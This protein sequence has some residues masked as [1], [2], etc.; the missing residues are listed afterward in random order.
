MIRRNKLLFLVISIMLTI[1]YF[2]NLRTKLLFDN[3]TF[4]FTNFN[5]DIGSRKLIV[6]NIVHFI[7]FDMKTLNF[8]TF[9][10]LLSAWY[11]HKPSKIY[12]HTNLKQ[13]LADSFYIDVLKNVT[14]EALEIHEL[15]KPTHVF[16]QRLSSTHHSSDIARIQILMKYGGIYLDEDV[17]VVKNLNRF[18]HFECS[19]GWP[20]TQNIGSQVILAHKDA[21]FLKLW[22]QLYREYRPTMW[23][24]NAGEAPTQQILTG[25]PHLV[26]RVKTAFGVENLTEEIYSKF[27]PEWINRHTIHLL[28]NHQYIHNTSLD[29]YNYRF[30]NCTFAVLANQMIDNLNEYQVESLQSAFPNSIETYFE[31]KVEKYIQSNSTS[32]LKKYLT[33]PVFHHLQPLKTKLYGST[34]HDVIKTGLANFDS[35]IGLFAPDAEAYSVFRQLFWPVIRDYHRVDELTSHPS[36]YWGDAAA[37]GSFSSQVIS[38]RIRVARSV[39]G[40]PFNS[41][42]SSDNL[43]QLEAKVRYVLDTQFRGKYYSLGNITDTERLMLLERHFLFEEC[44]RFT[45]GGGGCA[46]WPVGRGVFVTDAQNLIFW[47]NEEDHLRVISIEQ[48]GNLQS[49]YSRLAGAVNNLEKHLNF[50]HDKKLGFLTFCPTNIGTTLRSSV[51]VKFSTLNSTQIKSVADG[52]GLQVRGTSGEHTTVNGG[53]Y[54]ISNRRRFGLTELDAVSE[55]FAGVESLLDLDKL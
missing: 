7:Q 18:R 36:T 40:F 27:W 29:Q 44:D 14:G 34:L 1:I 13:V 23:Y 45:T 42:M 3:Q 48:G 21:R 31:R 30:C 22:L 49:V 4:D 41:K 33:V 52:F 54:D 25:L 6:P 26:H 43:L 38:T 10:C 17:Y 5:N 39:E 37:I 8:V 16:G 28:A 24:Y 15:K 47:I 12:L 53:V 2:Y 35:K 20:E 9:I 50:V 55:M 32:L 19:I 46:F 51:H 11:N